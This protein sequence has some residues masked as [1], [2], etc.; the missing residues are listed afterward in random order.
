MINTVIMKRKIIRLWAEYEQDGSSHKFME[1]LSPAKAEIL[2]DEFLDCQEEAK[3][4]PHDDR[5]CIQRNPGLRREPVSKER[6]QQLEK[7]M[8]K[9]DRLYMNNPHMIIEEREFLSDDLF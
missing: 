2:I 8:T 4:T 3:D 7:I 1:P 9:I 5:H 6:M